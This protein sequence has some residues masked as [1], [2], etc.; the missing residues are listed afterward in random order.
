[1]KNPKSIR[2]CGKC[3][4]KTSES[5]FNNPM[6]ISSISSMTLIFSRN[7]SLWKQGSIR[8]MA[9]AIKRTSV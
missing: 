1:M 2:I 7:L 6:V 9:R 8:I 4:V 3:G 5:K